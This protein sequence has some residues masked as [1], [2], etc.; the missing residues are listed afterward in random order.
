MSER[1]MDGWQRLTC[2]CGTDRFAAMV[3]LRWRQG[4]GLSQEPTGFFCLECHAVVDSATL[5][6]KAQH[7]MKKRELRDLE[8]ELQ[9]E[10]K[11]AVAA[12]GK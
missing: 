4:A 9:S 7:E 5:I 12:K 11:P 1:S 10:A 3:H 2:S 8:A 6:A